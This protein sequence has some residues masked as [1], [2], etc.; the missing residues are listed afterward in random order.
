MKIKNKFAESLER[1][2]CNDVAAKIIHNTSWL[3][4]DKVFTMIIGVFVMALVARYL[5]PENYGLYNYALAF[6]TLFTAL[7]T[8]GLET[9][10]V[11]SIVQ[12]E[13]EE[14]TILFTSLVLRVIGGIVLTLL[15]SVII[16]F[17]APND[18][19]VHLLVL[20]MSFTMIFKSLEVIEYWIQAYQK[21]KISSLIRMGA[22]I[23]SALLKVGFV[24][25]EGNLYHLALI[26][27]SD[28]LI[29]GIA[30]VVAYFKNRTSN[31]RW[32][33]KFQYAKSILSQSW[34]LI[35]SGLM[36]TIYMQIDKVMLGSMLSN[37]EELGIFS[38][39]TQIA[40]L[41]YFVPMA[42]ITSFKPVIMSKKKTDENSYVN[43]VQFLYTIV[44]WL[45]IGF[46]VFILLTSRIIIK[47]LYGSEYLEAAGILSVSIWA[48]TFAMLGTAASTWLVCEGL[49]KYS[50]VLVISG[51]I[52]N[53]S[54]NFILIP[55]LGGYGAAIATLATQFISN[56]VVP[57]FIKK[58]RYSSIMMMKA[59]M[60]KG[61]KK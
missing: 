61:L 25:L 45:S 18:E 59:F 58:V 16:R 29:V 3:V 54:L 50:T 44:A 40:G 21:S 9:L 13:E 6:V 38:A 30:L 39:A 43:A 47:I 42:I 24:I 48:G 41:W 12:Q 46:G 17:I 56:F 22:Y 37:K 7:S 35:I 23:L 36:I 49:Q 8:L 20:I 10:S 27:M 1:I 33:F 55:I 53:V 14:G 11:K 60:L 26:Y 4:G 19:R 31:T 34:Y 52:T 32:K 15:A 28:T 57:L 5:G 2:K 51:A